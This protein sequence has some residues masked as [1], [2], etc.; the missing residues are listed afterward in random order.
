MVT[1]APVTTQATVTL[2]SVQ[3]LMRVRG[4]PQP[5][6]SD[7]VEWIC[8]NLAGWS[9]VPKP[10]TTRTDRPYGTGSYRSRSFLGARTVAVEFVVTAPN[11]GAIRLVEQRLG[12]WCSDGGRLYELKVNDPPLRPQSALVELDDAIIT[13]Y[14]TNT[15]LRVSAQFAAPDP[16]KW[17]VD[18]MD[19]TALLP[20]A[21]A[22][23]L[24]YT[25]GLDYSG[26][27][28]DFGAAAVPAYAQI[29]NYG[30]APVGPFITL[31]GPVSS[32]QVFDRVTGWTLSYLGDLTA[33][34][35]LTVNCDEFPQRSQ[36]GHSALLN[37]TIN[38]GSHV[39]RS[40]DW[41]VLDPNAVAIYQL[42]ANVPTPGVLVVS[43][44]S[45]W[46]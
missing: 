32:P 21:A 7:G 14:R 34:D 9:G 38:A 4:R 44:R 16:R 20:V 41:P 30:T 43:A 3:L 8:T 39:V 18:W 12:S 5:V 36:V 45:A 23:G 35:T 27:G 2:D 40:G 6:D 11:S 13:Q 46:Y 1:L 22:D 15:S 42:N 37:G 19:R 29:A 17:D 28:L 10:R 25:N 26:G 33:S 31:T 24:D